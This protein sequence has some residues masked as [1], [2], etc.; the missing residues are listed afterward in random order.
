M[1]QKKIILD[2][3][4]QVSTPGILSQKDFARFS[5]FIYSGY[6]ITL[7]ASK[8]TMVE[9]RL[10]RRLRNLRMRSYSEYADFVFSPEGIKSEMIHLVDALTTNKTDFYR[11]P[12]CFEFLLEKGLKDLVGLQGNGGRKINV[13]SAGCSSGEEPYTLAMVLNKYAEQCQG[14]QYSI[15]A[16]DISTRILKTAVRAVYA[17]EKIEPVPPPKKK[18]YFMTSRNKA[19]KLVRVVPELRSRVKFRRVNLMD[20]SFS[21]EE[22][23]DIIFC[24]NVIIY[25]DKATQ[26]KL[27]NNFCRYLPKNGYLIL[28]HSEILTNMKVPLIKIAPTVYMKNG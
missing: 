26:E 23:P 21:F 13:W 25:F 16:T 11:E 10:N 9:S 3:D 24:R 1:N 12:D 7:S 27:L 20:N 6:G 5:E 8:K 2:I 19:Q 18:K 4:A 28:G 15:L 17:V 14:F 22:Q